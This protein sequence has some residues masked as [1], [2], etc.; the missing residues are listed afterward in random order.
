MNS[1]SAHSATDRSLFAE[2]GLFELESDGDIVVID[3]PEYRAEFQRDSQDFVIPIEPF[4]LLSNYFSPNRVAEGPQEFINISLR[5]RNIRVYEISD[6]ERKK[7]FND[8]YAD[9]LEPVY[10]NGEIFA[11]ADQ[12]LVKHPQLESMIERRRIIKDIL[13]G[14]HS[15]TNKAHIT[16]CEEFRKRIAPLLTT[17]WLVSRENLSRL[18]QLIVSFEQI[19]TEREKLSSVE[20]AQMLKKKM[21]V[22]CDYIF[23]EEC[24][25][26]LLPVTSR[27]LQPWPRLERVKIELRNYLKFED[28]L[29]HRA[30]NVT[31]CFEQLNQLLSFHCREDLINTL[32]QD[33]TIDRK[34]E[35]MQTFHIVK[36][37]F[38]ELIL[39]FVP[40]IDHC[41]EQM[42]RF[43]PEAAQNI[44]SDEA[45]TTRAK[46]EALSCSSALYEELLTLSTPKIEEYFQQVLENLPDGAREDLSSALQAA[47]TYRE[48]KAVIRAFH[49]PQFP[50]DQHE[51]RSFIE[52]LEMFIAPTA[53]DLLRPVEMI[54]SSVAEEISAY[55]EEPFE[56]RFLSPGKEVFDS[57]VAKLRPLLDH[58]PKGELQQFLSEVDVNYCAPIPFPLPLDGFMGFMTLFVKNR[59][60][61]LF[62]EDPEPATGYELRYNKLVELKSDARDSLERVCKDT[63]LRIEFCQNG[64]EVFFGLPSIVSLSEEGERSFYDFLSEEE[65][66]VTY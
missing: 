8:G 45:L 3:F 59:N 29:L 37:P 23:E 15:T 38:E 56:N 35:R 64:R 19:S 46:I 53:E 50:L 24:L 55:L 39:P 6:E 22:D 52:Y 34:I 48:K 65:E 14:Y 60:V 63:G 25:P 36:L 41:Y 16:F 31:S 21:S 17:Y 49:V 12:F 4:L 11:V 26:E 9:L 61:P 51:E 44:S 18:R 20:Y 66:E 2:D 58:V 7:E 47:S 54:E 62:L 42:L 27:L 32:N 5:G 43:C 1:V 57:V 40:I 33:L 13:T 28:L 30:P 10:L